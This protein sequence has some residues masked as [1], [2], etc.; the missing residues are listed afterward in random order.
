M[1]IVNVAIQTYEEFRELPSWTTPDQ[2]DTYV[3]NDAGVLL[4]FENRGASAIT[5]TVVAL[6]ECSHEDLHSVPIILGNT[7]DTRIKIYEHMDRHR[8]NNAQDRVKITFSALPTDVRVVALR[9]FLR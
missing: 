2:A 3:M 9:R 1:P 5:A 4:L 8:F 6:R 7:A